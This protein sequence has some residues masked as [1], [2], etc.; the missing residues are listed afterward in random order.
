MATKAKAK[1]RGF[2]A[3]QKEIAKKQGISLERAGAILAAGA[4]K[5]SP[6]AIRKNPRLKKISGVVKKKASAK[7][8]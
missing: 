8:K 2:K 3:V 6:E 1:H 5:A 7:K 4:R